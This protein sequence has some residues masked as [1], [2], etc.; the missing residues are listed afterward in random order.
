MI[1]GTKLPGPT[2]LVISSVLVK[3]QVKRVKS[4]GLFK[5]FANRDDALAWL[6]SWAA[7]LLARPEPA[8]RRLLKCFV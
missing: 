6:G 3:L 2:A 7:G 8:S 4:G 1:A 5:V